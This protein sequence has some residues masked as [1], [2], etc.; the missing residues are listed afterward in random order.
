[1]LRKGDRKFSFSDVSDV[2]PTQQQLKEARHFLEC[3]FQAEALRKQAPPPS[4]VRTVS[5]YLFDCSACC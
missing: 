1:M 3:M 4:L 2:L 5:T